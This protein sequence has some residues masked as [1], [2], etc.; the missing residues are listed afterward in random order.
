MKNKII[1]IF[2]TSIA[3]YNS[4]NQIIMDAVNVEV[5]ELFENSFIISLPIEDIKTNARKY[6]SKSDL[7]FVGGT[8]LLNSDI[9]RYRQWDLTLH[10]IYILSNLVLLGCGWFQYEKKTI[11][12]YTRWAYRRILSSNYLH[13]VRDDYTKKKLE[14]IGIDAIN[15]GCPTLWRLTNDILK[16]IPQKKQKNVVI[17]LTDYNRKKERDLLLLNTC[18]KLYENVYFY[19][20]GTGDISYLQELGYAEKVKI[21]APNLE[22]FGDILQGGGVDYIGTRLHAGIRAL[23]KSA[24]SFIVGIDNR[25][26]EMGHDFNLPVIK[27]ADLSQLETLVCNEYS[28]NLS[29]PFGNIE[30]WKAQFLIEK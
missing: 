9:R 28:L 24:R 6:N 10:N 27:E 8:N 30:K 23:Q 11:T 22:T 20:Q 17:V 3:S 13:S 18:L 21:L 16:D 19:P 5:R 14:S 12:R 15:T 2:D 7:S 25:A 4:G 1:S 29:I 26:I